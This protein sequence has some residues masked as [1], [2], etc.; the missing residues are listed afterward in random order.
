MP[1]WTLLAEPYDGPAASRLVPLVQ[2]EYVDRYGGP[3]DTPIEPAEFRPPAG[4]FLVG[5]V[6]GDAVACGGLR[7][8]REGIAEIKRM[9]VAPGWRRRGLGRRLLAGL[10]QAATNAG[11][12]EVWLETGTAQPEALELYRSAGYAPIPAYGHY[13]CAPESRC[14][15]K[16]LA[17]SRP[18][19]PCP[20]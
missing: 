2:A 13:R 12:R 20:P 16:R 18:A 19:A 1:E 8:L 14:F 3:D 15:G 6:A 7:R 10:E 5:Y 17:I 4:L 11:Y 9:Y